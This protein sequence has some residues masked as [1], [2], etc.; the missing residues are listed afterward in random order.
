M[1]SRIPVSRYRDSVHEE[2]N[3]ATA[4]PC[5]SIRMNKTQSRSARRLCGA[6]L[7]YLI[8]LHRSAPPRP[9]PRLLRLHRKLLRLVF[10]LSS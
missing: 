1:R 3:S 6:E 5:A 9:H 7:T 4:I 2:Q 8:L 10:R